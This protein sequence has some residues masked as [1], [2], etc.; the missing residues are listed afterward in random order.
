M[1]GCLLSAYLLLAA[2][3]NAMHGHW[4]PA[5]VMLGLGILAGA[6]FAPRQR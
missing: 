4:L 6:L 5:V 2:V 3:V 1:I